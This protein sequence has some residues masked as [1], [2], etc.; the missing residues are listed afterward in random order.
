MMGR[1]R[2]VEER[3]LSK[4]IQNG[5]NVVPCFM[6][7]VLFLY[8]LEIFGAQQA[9][10]GGLSVDVDDSESVGGARHVYS[11]V[12]GLEASIA[13][14]RSREK[15]EA[16]GKDQHIQR[17][18]EKKSQKWTRQARQTVGKGRRSEVLVASQSR[19]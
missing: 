5:A 15:D 14:L 8:S 16:A 10:D 3:T 2:K 9:R 4:G 13:L 6:G 18:P 12:F 17:A 1:A 19:W 7:F 11:V